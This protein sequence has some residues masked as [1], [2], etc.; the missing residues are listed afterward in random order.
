MLIPIKCVVNI[1]NCPPD[2]CE[3]ARK[4][5]HYC[6]IDGIE[7][8]ESN[9]VTSD[10]RGSCMIIR[11]D[12][13]FKEVEHWLSDT[14]VILISDNMDLD[15]IKS[16]VIDIIPPSFDDDRFA[17]AFS[18]MVHRVSLKKHLDIRENLFNT[19][20][21]ISDN[22]L[23]TKDMRDFHMDINHI[24]ID[25][26]GKP[27]EQ[28]EGKHEREIYG[29]DPN[30]EGCGE[31]DNYV[32]TTGLTNYFE[33]SMP[34]ADGQSHHLQV[35]KTPWKDGQGRIIGTVGLA[36]DVTDLLN[37]EKKFE[38]FLDSMDLGVAIADK[39]G[40]IIEIND[41]FRDLIK[42]GARDPVGKSFE[43]VIG[44]VSR[45]VKDYQ[46]NDY[47][48]EL[49]DVGRTI[50]NMSR[51]TLRDYW[52]NDTGDVYIMQNVTSEREHRRRIKE[53][54][55]SDPLTG[56][57]NRAGLYEYYDSLDKAGYATFMFADIDNFKQINDRFGHAVGDI[58]LKDV[59]N[60]LD[61]NIPGSFI[62]RVGG[63]EF[64]AITLSDANEEVIA[65]M[66]DQINDDMGRLEGYPEGFSPS[67]SISMGVLYHAPLRLD[68]DEIM[69]KCD[70]AMYKA[71]KNGKHGYHID[72]SLTD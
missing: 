31:S 3:S 24:L 52:E 71:K 53:M 67:A 20:Y 49:P 30:D 57:A 41:T 43:D 50:W 21:E 35:T 1:I 32:R 9:E 62:V 69:E 2:I 47:M 39:N 63:D 12:E 5:E 51:S 26:V 40:T 15:K 18:N 59:V 46:E 10:M 55:V 33:E 17:V 27:R 16:G 61:K 8:N 45:S 48:I 19:Y 70:A 11:G 36:K 60:I 4:A 66:A 28:I 38:T 14:A 56:V 23:W 13:K 7:W 22:M 29:L 65:E 58:F 44:S 34:G 6:N 42:N 25:L 64:F 54:A 37:Q 72:L 68:I